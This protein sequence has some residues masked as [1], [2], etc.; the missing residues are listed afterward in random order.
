MYAATA[1]IQL[2]KAKLALKKHNETRQELQADVEDASSALYDSL[3]WADTKP[4]PH[5][6]FVL[7]HDSVTYVIAFD[8]ATGEPLVDVATPLTRLTGVVEE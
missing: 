1:A 5:F 3:S 7:E 8:S 2:I 6:P 4:T